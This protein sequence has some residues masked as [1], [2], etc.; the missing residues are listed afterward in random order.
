MIKQLEND[1][2]LS[3]PEGLTRQKTIPT[4]HPETAEEAADILVRAAKHN[5]KL[6]ISGF[7][8]NI[9]PSGDRYANLLV[10]KS[11]RLNSIVDIAP[12]DF[13]ITVGSGYPLKEINKV[14]AEQNLYF[15][16]SD[17]NYPGSCGGALAAGLT[18]FDGNHIV[19]FSRQLLGVT[20]VLP[21]GSII[22]P[23]AKTFKSVSGYDISR[24]FF[25]SWGL[26]GFIVQLT[27]RV[28]PLSKKDSEPRIVPNHPDRAG[29]ISDYRGE[30]PL[31]EMC[32]KIKAEYDQT[33]L[34][35]LI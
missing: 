11:D 17:T 3:Y 34:L 18:G 35:P 26:L 12:A 23:G 24:M 13:H 20:A 21:D 4:F 10:L 8:N 33:E 19:P 32:R 16:F 27:F 2:A 6:F 5:Q 28:L 22:K 29:F 25:N 14:I 30:T 31:S 9:D 15:P 1:I 7:G